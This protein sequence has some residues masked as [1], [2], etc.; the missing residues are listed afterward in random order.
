MFIFPYSQLK[1][2]RQVDTDRTKSTKLSSSCATEDKIQSW[3]SESDTDDSSI[4]SVRSVV[5]RVT[6]RLGVKSPSNED[7]EE[8]NPE[9]SAEASKQSNP[10]RHGMSKW[11]EDLFIAGGKVE[12]GVAFG[13]RSSVPSNDATS[14]FSSLLPLKQSCHSLPL[15][16][17]RLRGRQRCGERLDFPSSK[18]E[19]VE[20]AAEA[21]NSLKW[22]SC[23]TRSGLQAEPS[24]YP[25]TSMARPSSDPQLEI[26]RCNLRKEHMRNMLVL[27]VEEG[28]NLQ[29]N[30]PDNFEKN[31][32]AK[33]N[34]G[35]S[36]FLGQYQKPR[37][38]RQELLCLGLPNLEQTCYM[39]STLQGLLTLK[40]FVQEVLNQKEVWSSCPHSKI[41]SGFVKVELCRSSN[42]E[43]EKTCVLAAFKEI[44]A[45]V[46]TEFEDDD[47]K[48]AHEFL[49]CV[50]NTMG[51]LT[52]TFQ[53]AAHIMGINYTCP[54]NAHIAFQMLS[55]RTCRGCCMQSAILEDYI[56]LSLD[57][58]PE[59][60]TS[61][62]LEE[63]L[64][65]SMLEYK[66]KC[67][68]VESTQRSSFS[69]L[70]N[71]LILQ[72]KRFAYTPF[73]KEIKL[74]YPIILSR[75]LEVSLN[76][77]STQTQKTCYSLVSI[78]S[79]LGSTSHCGHY[80]CDGAQRETSGDLSDSWLTYND[81]NVWQTSGTFVCQQ[82]QR[83]AYLLFYEKTPHPHRNK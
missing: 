10:A 22:Q 58:V 76:S 28:A 26:F 42:N 11:N 3:F 44:I 32:K 52:C 35:R 31:L 5:E 59:G 34:F 23:P 82:R 43:T 65:E 38:H 40:L 24:F 4:E 57:L 48:D 18:E 71:V 19:N 39:N 74:D 62:C 14:G 49:S 61:D 53:T 37:I 17:V 75:E 80:I 47:Q 7:S 25:Q 8:E 66:C 16:M 78:I 63:Y 46:D 20:V 51:S 64:K 55:T 73:Y 50:L 21:N 2:Q 13:R 77:S 15:S 60:S 33:L 81:S 79:H 27:S 54:V 30:S 69:N 12:P 9:V 45:E 29:Q 36:N 83:T 1:R 41:M 6:S 67:G 70:P 72:L 56:N 68:A